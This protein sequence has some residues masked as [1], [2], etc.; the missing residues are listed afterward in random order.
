MS[1]DAKQ[2]IRELIR[3]RI[4]LLDTKIELGGRLVASETWRAAG[5]VL[6]FSPLPDEPQFSEVWESNDGKTLC[7]PR[8]VADTGA[9]EAAVIANRE[10]DLVKGKFGIPEPGPECSSLLLNQL[11]LVLVPGV[12]FTPF[13]ARLGRGRGFYDRILAAVTGRKIGV[14]FD[15]QLVDELPVESHDQW[16]DAILTPT[17]WI[18]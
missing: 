10:T 2:Q 15:E 9:Y 4:A 5:R 17:R 14:A 16:V 6:L 11:D 12:A 8:F 1:A 18:T 3:E 7:L 13:G